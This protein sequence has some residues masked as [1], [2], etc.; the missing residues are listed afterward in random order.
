M[1]STLVQISGFV[2]QQQQHA[3]EVGGIQATYYLG[4][5]PS[6]QET[7]CSWNYLQAIHL[8]YQEE[9]LV[10]GFLLASWIGTL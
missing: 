9:L 2:D 8:S 10:L 1:I 5:I 3:V 4:D 7:S 6:R